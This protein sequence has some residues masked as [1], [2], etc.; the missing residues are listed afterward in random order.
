[1]KCSNRYW[2]FFIEVTSLL[3]ATKYVTMFCSIL[4]LK[5]W[6]DGILVN[7]FIRRPEKMTPN[8]SLMMLI[9]KLLFNDNWF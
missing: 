8:D 1:M 2:I 6:Y 7:M 3:Q 4:Y 9:H 5:E